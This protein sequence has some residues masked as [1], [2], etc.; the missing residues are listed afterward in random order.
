MNLQS[1]SLLFISWHSG[2]QTHYRA[3]VFLVSLP[4]LSKSP[5]PLCILLIYFPLCLISSRSK[6]KSMIFLPLPTRSLPHP[7]HFFLTFLL[8]DLLK[9]S[10]PSRVVNLSSAAH[11]LGKIQ[12]DDLSSEKGYHP[13]RA[14]AQSKLANILFTREL[15]K[16]T[17]GRA[18][19]CVCVCDKVYASC[20]ACL[21]F[22][23]FLCLF[24]C[25]RC[26]KNRSA[27]LAS[28]R[29]SCLNHN[30]SGREAQQ[31]ETCR[32]KTLDE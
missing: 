16:R 4:L 12:F 26:V 11:S 20:T 25:S 22:C 30:P 2:T 27:S 13:V 7:G 18:C 31:G 10:A 24:S 19:V 23:L 5:E 3:A 28:V 15:A 17:E 1:P 32:W 6:K 29:V 14:Y 21:S 9:H 8:L